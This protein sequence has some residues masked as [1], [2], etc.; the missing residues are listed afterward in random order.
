AA[1]LARLM[2]EQGMPLARLTLGLATRHPEVF[3]N[4]VEWTDEQGPRKLP[5][6]HDVQATRAF[7]NSPVR[8]IQE[9]ATEIR[10]RLQGS[11]ADLRFEICKDLAARGATDYV[12]F[13]LPLSSGQVTTASFASRDPIGFSEAQLGSLREAM[14]AL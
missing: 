13:A 1:E 3:L 12:I 4:T 9:G 14:P 11:A 8:A 2:S 5:R 7:Q 6:L 10:C